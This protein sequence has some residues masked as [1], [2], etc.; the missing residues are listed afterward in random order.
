MGNRCGGTPVQTP[1]ALTYWEDILEANPEPVRKSHYWH[2]RITDFYW[3][4]W[5]MLSIPI[6]FYLSL[7]L[8]LS[9]FIKY[10]FGVRWNHCVLFVTFFFSWIQAV[11]VT[12][13]IRT[14][15]IRRSSIASMP[16]FS[17]SD[18]GP[19]HR[20]NIRSQDP[21]ARDTGRTRTTTI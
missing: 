14:F 20:Q 18:H 13:L 3:S 16:D 6:N 11:I 1:L 7:V 12:F 8:C 15:L 10:E 9:F 17:L 21:L 2:N 4:F 19:H 5:Q